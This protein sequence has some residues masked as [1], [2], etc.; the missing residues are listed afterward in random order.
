MNDRQKRPGEIWWAYHPWLSRVEFWN[1]DGSKVITRSLYRDRPSQVRI[2]CKPHPALILAPGD[3]N[4]RGYLVCYLS[5]HSKPQDEIQR[6]L[7]NGVTISDTKANYAFSMAPCYCDDDF[8]WGSFPIK[9]ADSGMLELVKGILKRSSLLLS[10]Q[11][12]E[13]FGFTSIP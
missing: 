7:L 12:W 2:D 1:K 4:R 13:S 6:R 5:S 9:T 3:E 10:T 11:N 8:I